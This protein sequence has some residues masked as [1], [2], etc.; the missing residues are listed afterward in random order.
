MTI[1]TVVFIVYLALMLGVSFYAGRSKVSDSE[2]FFLGGRKIGGLATGLSAA[3]SGRSGG[4]MLGN[5]GL[6]FVFG[7]HACLLYTSRCV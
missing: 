4:T 1:I 6:A 3:A 5:A 7:F 2:D